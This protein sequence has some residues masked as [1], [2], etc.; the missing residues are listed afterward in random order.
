MRTIIIF[1]CNFGFTTKA[2]C[3]RHVK[4]KHGKNSRVDIR[5]SITIHENGEGDE[6]QLFQTSSPVKKAKEEPAPKPT[7]KPSSALFAPYSASLYRPIVNNA[8]SETKESGEACGGSG[9]AP[10]DLSRST[11]IVLKPD[12]ARD[13]F[14]LKAD[15]EA[16]HNEMSPF[17]QL[18]F[19]F[20]LRQ[21]A[22]AS[23]VN[24]GG[25]DFSSAAYLLAAQ[26]E[27]IRRQQQQQQHKQQHQQQQQDPANNPLL[28]HL[29]NLQ[30]SLS[31]GK[32]PQPQVP[33]SSPLLPSPDNN[34]GA[35]EKGS[36]D[37][38]SSGEDSADYKMVIKNG[39]LMR[40]Q[41]QKR[42]RTEKPFAC[43]HCGERFT[44]RSN[45][46]R[47]VKQQHLIKKSLDGSSWTD[48]M[49]QREEEMEADDEDEH[50]IVD[51]D[52]D[53]DGNDRAE[54]EAKDDSHGSTDEDGYVDNEDAVEEEEEKKSAYATAPNK[55]PCRFCN[56]VFPWASS[57]ERHILT[58]T[59]EKSYRCSVKECNTWF[60][61]KSN[62]DRHLLRKH[63][64]NNNEKSHSNGVPERPFRCLKCPNSTFSSIERLRNHELGEHANQNVAENEVLNRSKDSVQSDG[65][66]TPFKCFLC[67]DAFG[68]R[69]EAIEHLKSSHAS[70]YESLLAK[71]AFDAA[72]MTSSA[73]SPP[74]FSSHN[75][76]SE[77]DDSFDQLRGKFPD[78]AN[79]KVACLF[80]LRKFSSAEDFR[81]HARSHSG[82]RPYKCDVC[83]KRFSLKHSM[84]RHKK[85]H[86]SNA[87]SGDDDEEDEDRES[88]F[89]SADEREKGENDVKKKRANLMDKIN[90]LSTAVLTEKAPTDDE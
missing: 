37:P 68:E 10:L 24:G 79:R 36:S 23:A 2:N 11:E 87:N 85:K 74:S 34:A 12:E 82:E 7:T 28:M 51:D 57:L 81:R 44:L 61:T 55:L 70:N 59:G 18:P 52:D 27:M 25:F 21:L 69:G 73:S 45:M 39:V 78:Y 30:A 33:G 4:N 72:L 14:K 80:C 86:E 88:T 38:Q 53:D 77:E 56:R 50:L 22:A 42:Y 20:I 29:S 35:T 75:A 31:A 19:P 46:D 49:Q 26:Q 32:S 3:E 15:Y 40:K 71:N 17:G 64:D 90:K 47:H 84:I 58:H 65:S 67:E 48:A 8:E 41:K 89:S 66:A 9:D 76:N 83:D 13:G 60:T 1:S 43:S 16:S 5:D 6:E 62:C 54:T 63:G